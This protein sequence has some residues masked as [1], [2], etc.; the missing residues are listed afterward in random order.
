V[1]VSLASSSPTTTTPGLS[2]SEIF[3]NSLSCPPSCITFL[4]SPRGSL[5][6]SRALSRRAVSLFAIK[7]ERSAV[8]ALWAVGWGKLC[9]KDKRRRNRPR[10][11]HGPKTTRKWIAILSIHQNLP[12]MILKKRNLR[13]LQRRS[14]RQSKFCLRKKKLRNF[15]PLTQLRLS[16]ANRIF[17]MNLSREYRSFS[18]RTNTHYFVN[19]RFSYQPAG[20]LIFPFP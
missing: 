5:F 15:L 7:P 13:I 19:E 17:S 3:S 11:P 18:C 14:V 4:D 10:H 12:K 2:D 20:P 6:S 8:V 1:N 16:R 9:S